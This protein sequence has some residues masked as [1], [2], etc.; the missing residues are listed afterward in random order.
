MKP[1]GRLLLLTTQREHRA[2]NEEQKAARRLRNA[3]LTATTT[4]AAAG[5]HRAPVTG[6]VGGRI[7]EY[8]PLG[9][10]HRIITLLARSGEEDVVT[11]V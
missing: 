5:G 1:L 10:A 11:I 4:T 2:T 3:A 6:T 9:T 7:S 8:S